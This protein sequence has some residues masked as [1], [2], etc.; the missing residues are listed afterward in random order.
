MG[1]SSLCFVILQDGTPIVCTG[2]AGHLDSGTAGFTLTFGNLPRNGFGAQGL[3]PIVTVNDSSAV[4]TTA[5]TT[6]GVPHTGADTLS[7]TSLQLDYYVKLFRHCHLAYGKFKIFS[8]E[9][10]DGMGSK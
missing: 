4:V 9:P 10:Y 6:P 3:G 5:Y 1:K 7:A 2:S 8:S